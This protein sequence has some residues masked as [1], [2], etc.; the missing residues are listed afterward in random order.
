MQASEFSKPRWPVVTWSL[1]TLNLVMLIV[2]IF[3]GGTT[4]SSTLLR[5]GAAEMWTV[6]EG[7]WWRLLTA[8]FLHAGVLH[9]VINMLSLLI[10]GPFIERMLGRIGCALLYLLS[11]FAGM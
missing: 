4:N 8:N 9:L 1:V 7:Q 5:L 6:R 3:K 10:I 11:G 2:E